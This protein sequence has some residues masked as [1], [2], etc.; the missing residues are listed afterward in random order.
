MRKII[1][2]LYKKERHG[3]LMEKWWFRAILV[4]YVITFLIAPFAI[5]FWHVHESSDWCYN[6]LYNYYD[7]QTVFN[8]QL[9]DCS[10]FARE[11]WV[12]GVPLAILGWLVVHYFVQVIFFKTF[13]DY[14]I[15]GG[16]K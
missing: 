12:K 2:P 8:Y 16:K 10:R 9:A 15:L 5:W 14:I 7:D 4:F 3:F 13:I 11:A 6:S 1:F